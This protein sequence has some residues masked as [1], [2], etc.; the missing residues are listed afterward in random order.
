MILW[1]CINLSYKTVMLHITNPECHIDGDESG[2]CNDCAAESS[3]G[4]L[5]KRP[6]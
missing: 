4:E 1:N 6:R 5:V 2:I 3:V